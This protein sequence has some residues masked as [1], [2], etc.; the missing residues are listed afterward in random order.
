MVEPCGAG[1]PDP[2]PPGRV[3]AAAPTRSTKSPVQTPRTRNAR[4]PTPG[5]RTSTP[6]SGQ[7]IVDITCADTG[8][9]PGHRTRGRD[10]VLGQGDLD[11]AGTGQTSRTTTTTRPPPGTPNRGP[12]DGTC[13]ARQRRRLGDD[14]VPASARLPTALPGPAQSLCRPSRALAHCC[15][16]TITGRRRA[17][18]EASSVMASA[19]SG[20]KS[21]VEADALDR[22][23]RRGAFTR[24]QAGL[25][26]VLGSQRARYRCSPTRSSPLARHPM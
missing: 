20:V 6:D 23:E 7:R 3:A 13:C 15:P 18:G 1:R 5:H 26:L 22:W 11:T 16:R 19:G 24:G 14:E 4:T 9:S 2:A 8:R 21:P 17:N 12:V 25:D 10:R